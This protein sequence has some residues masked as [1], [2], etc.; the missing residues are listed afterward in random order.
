MALL[1]VLTQNTM[2]SIELRDY[3]DGEWLSFNT[4]RWR[5][6]ER[7][8]SPDRTTLA[9]HRRYGLR[10]HTDSDV[11]S[12]RVSEYRYTHSVCLLHRITCPRSLRRKI[13]SMTSAQQTVTV[14]WKEVPPDP[15]KHINL[16][17]FSINVFNSG[18]VADE[19]KRH[20]E[21]QRVDQWRK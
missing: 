13:V 9:R 10:P 19:N 17:I 12:G 5:E 15:I 18:S 3:L 14:S 1:Y 4:N 2:I 21:K 16:F 11:T 6:A 20:T 8:N 7:Y